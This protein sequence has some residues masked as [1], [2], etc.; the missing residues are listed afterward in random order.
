MRT[1]ETSVDR[2]TSGTA[3]PRVWLVAAVCGSAEPADRPAVRDDLMRMWR[4][5]HDDLYRTVDGRR[6][7]T[8]AEL[9]ERFDLVEV[10]S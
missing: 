2:T 1:D 7:A 8:W 6:C 9:R 3:R 5:G 10:A 4:P